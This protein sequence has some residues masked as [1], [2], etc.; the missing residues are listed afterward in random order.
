MIG[1]SILRIAAR[2]SVLVVT[3]GRVAVTRPARTLVIQAPAGLPGPPGPQGPPGPGGGGGSGG[4]YTHTQMVASAL[5]TIAHNLGYRPAVTVYDTASDQIWG[6]VDHV[7]V[8]N[9][10]IAFSSAISGSAYMS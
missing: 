4:S 8:N 9:L 3:D 6:D 1:H 10:T 7:D 5:W 2:T